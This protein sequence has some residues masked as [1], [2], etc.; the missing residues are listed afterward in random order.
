MAFSSD[1][2][3]RAILPAIFNH[4][5]TS[6]AQYHEPASKELGRDIRHLWIPR[7]S[8]V[9]FKDFDTDRLDADQWKQAA[10]LRVLAYHVLPRLVLEAPLTSTKTASTN[11][12]KADT[13]TDSTT[14]TSTVS[15]P[16]YA[17]L[18][19]IYKASYR[20]EI[21]SAINDGVYYDSGNGL[22]RIQSTG[23]AESQRRIR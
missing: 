10:C 3:L 14:S 5:L 17:A 4:G 9:L 7:Q 8:T 13:V 23:K 19:T 2:D 1:S 20:D 11:A 21:E 12:T 22:K 6:F 16:D 15:T 18:I